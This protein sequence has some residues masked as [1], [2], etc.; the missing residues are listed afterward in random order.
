[1]GGSPTHSQKTL[2]L[3]GVRSGKSAYAESLLWDVPTR[4]VATARPAGDDA[5][6]AAR[7]AGHVA[8]RP[9]SWTLFEGDPRS[10]LTTR[11]V[12][13]VDDIGG[14]LVNAID[15]ADAWDAPAGTIDTAPLVEAISQFPD[16]LMLV[17][18]EVG[19]G[20]LPGT[21]SG[22]LFC[23]EMGALNQ[24]LAE[25][26]DEVVLVVAGLPLRLKG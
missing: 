24:R 3:G 19:L 5:D 6:F 14:W 22:R 20:V 9:S 18:P 4:Y 12:T 8:R 23:D 21:S 10:A 17:S 15:D 1:M 25:V 13:L 2:V 16:R 26:C 11:G 7:I